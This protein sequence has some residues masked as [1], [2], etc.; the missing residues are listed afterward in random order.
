MP[1]RFAHASFR[2]A[3]RKGG[4]LVKDLSYFRFTVC[5]VVGFAQQ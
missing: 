2:A 5:V 3:P 1:D 4:G